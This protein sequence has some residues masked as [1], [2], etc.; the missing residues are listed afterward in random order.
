[1][2][3]SKDSKLFYRFEKNYWKYF[4]ELEESFIATKRYVAFDRVNYKTYSSEYLKLLEAVCSEIDVVAK[5]IAHQIN[6]EFK[7]LDHSDIQ[8]WWYIIQDWFREDALEPVT[9]TNELEF[10]PW[11]GYIIEQYKDK[12]GRACCKLSGN[13][14]TPHWWTSY[15]KVKHSRTLEDPNT[16][17]PYFQQ[18]NLVNLCNAFAALYLLEKRYMMSIGQ[19]K[20][21]SECQESQLFGAFSSKG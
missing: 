4:L 17:K 18:A 8:R 10:S 15:N 21:Y 14:K 12:K 9:M 1:M 19:K 5:E 16:K 2:Q 20:E 6:P 11:S 13:S 7:I 3:I